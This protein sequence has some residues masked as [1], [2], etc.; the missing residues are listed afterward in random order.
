MV[1]LT[2]FT[3]T[4]SGGGPERP[5]DTS[6]A[7]ALSSPAGNTRREGQLWD[8]SSMPEADQQRY[9]P[10]VRVRVLLSMRVRERRTRRAVS[11]Y[12]TTSEGVATSEGS[13]LIR[14]WAHGFCKAKSAPTYRLNGLYGV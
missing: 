10:S 14:A 1:V 11:R 13:H 12:P 8:L 3:R 6:S 4:H 7:G 5:A 9:G 2:P